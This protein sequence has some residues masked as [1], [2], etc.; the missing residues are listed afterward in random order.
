MKKLIAAGLVAGTLALASN[1]EAADVSAKVTEVFGD[2]YETERVEA[3]V[4]KLPLNSELY[5]THE[6]YSDEKP[7]FTKVRFQAFPLAT[8]NIKLGVGIQ[9]VNS[10]KLDLG[11]L[12]RLQGKP[13][14]NLFVKSDFRYWPDVEPNKDN[15]LENYSLAIATI[16]KLGI[17][18]VTADILSSYNIDTKASMIRPSIEVTPKLPF[19]LPG[20][21]ELSL[22]YEWK[23][24]GTQASFDEAYSGVKAAI[25]GKW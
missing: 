15:L 17:E 9:A 18:K 16:K 13:A 19:K 24:T 21:L 2:K 14:E 20:N 11:G 7:S 4:S 12:L 23:Y 25:S 5:V 22:G 10:N 1:A 6:D 3:S 8:D